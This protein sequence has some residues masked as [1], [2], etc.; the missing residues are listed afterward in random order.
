MTASIHNFYDPNNAMSQEDVV[1]LV[2]NAVVDKPASARLALNGVGHLGA[3]LNRMANWSEIQTELTGGRPIVVSSGKHVLVV[4]GFKIY[5]D[6]R[7][8]LYF[9]DSEESGPRSLSYAAFN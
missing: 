2:F 1:E 9:Y 3:I 5:S 4:Y 8:L 6:G 7:D